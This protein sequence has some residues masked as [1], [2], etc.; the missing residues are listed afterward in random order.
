MERLLIE[1]AIRSTL[2][3]AVAAV[4]LSALRIKNVAARHSAWTCVL[5][6]MLALP[7]LVAS[8]R[9]VP[10]RILPALRQNP[11]QVA[12]SPTGKVS[13]IIPKIDQAVAE[14][15]KAV[16]KAGRTAW[17]QWI[18]GVY[19]L[20]VTVLLLRLVIGMIG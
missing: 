7:L 8:G 13:V 14:S 20:G 3:G 2:I 11:E 10:L 6:F 5:V 19:F 12:Q 9:S 18:E 15:P 4:V 17:S 1:C 16:T